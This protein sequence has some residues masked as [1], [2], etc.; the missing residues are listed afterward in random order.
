MWK[1]VKTLDYK[2][3]LL[4]FSLICPNLKGKENAEIKARESMTGRKKRPE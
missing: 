3:E 4:F 1:C 2:R